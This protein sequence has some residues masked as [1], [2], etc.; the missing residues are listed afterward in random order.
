[1]SQP[2]KI[3][4]PDD[5]AQAL[6]WIAGY[7]RTAN[8]TRQF[9]VA[10]IEQHGESKI[11]LTSSQADL[12]H[13]IGYYQLTEWLQDLLGIADEC[14]RLMGIAQKRGSD[15]NEALSTIADLQQTID[16]ARDDA[17]LARDGHEGAIRELDSARAAVAERDQK[18]ADLQVALRRETSD[19][20]ALRQ[21]L[22]ATEREKNGTLDELAKATK[23]YLDEVAQMPVLLDG[24]RRYR[25]VLC[26]AMRFIGQ[27][28]TDARL[29]VDDWEKNHARKFPQQ[30][31]PSEKVISDSSTIT[32]NS[33]A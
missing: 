19:A 1:M 2:D 25:R 24:I 31:A 5:I 20:H 17:R 18:L 32:E 11:I 27:T 3:I 26:P 33:E 22:E 21:R 16:R 14:D 29:D 12:P 7:L 10:E 13:V 4:L 15:L 23:T 9:A 6:H 28:E 30:P 8:M